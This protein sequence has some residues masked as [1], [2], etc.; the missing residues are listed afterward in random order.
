MRGG[1]R[2]DAGAIVLI[3]AIGY[4]PTGEVFNLSAADVAQSVAAELGADKLV[5]LIEG[6]GLTDARG[7]LVSNARPRD[8]ERILASRRRLPE[9]LVQALRASLSACRN[10][11]RRVHILSRQDDGALL[12]ELFTRDGTGTLLA[13]EPYEKTRTANIEDVGGILGL[14]APSQ[15]MPPP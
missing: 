13:D 6:R 1:N 12:K 7:H 5:A 10:G 8:V 9:D 2:L 15:R 3:P 14:L 11:V 4:S